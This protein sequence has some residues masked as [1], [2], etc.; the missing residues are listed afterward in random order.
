MSTVIEELQQLYY[1]LDNSS[2]R[3]VNIIFIDPENHPDTQERDEEYEKVAE[4]YYQENNQDF[5]RV[6]PGESGVTPKH[7]LDYVNY[8]KEVN[9]NDIYF[10]TFY[11]KRLQGLEDSEEENLYDYG[12]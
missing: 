8:T 9:Y 5:Y 4:N 2:R 6:Y 10:A 7:A 12:H 11:D 3:I 1:A